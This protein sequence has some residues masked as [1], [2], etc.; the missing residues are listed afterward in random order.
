MGYSFLCIFLFQH[1]FQLKVDTHWMFESG[2]IDLFILLGPGPKDVSR[3]YGELTGNTPLPPEFSIG[4]PYFHFNQPGDS[5]FKGNAASPK[6][7]GCAWL[8]GL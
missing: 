2:I 4:R 5:L 3:Q 1:G 8:L 7:R 6:S